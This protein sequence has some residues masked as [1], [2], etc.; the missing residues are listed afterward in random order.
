MSDFRRVT[1]IFTAGLAAVPTGGRPL[2][3]GDTYPLLQALAPILGDNFAAGYFIFRMD[4]LEAAGN[5]V[6]GDLAGLADGDALAHCF[7]LS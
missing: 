1:S 7:A 2:L 4:N 3:I 5:G 6:V